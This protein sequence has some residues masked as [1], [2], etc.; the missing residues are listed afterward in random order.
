MFLLW[1]ALRRHGVYQPQPGWARH[2]TR[3]AT[4]C[5]VMVAILLVGLWFWN[6]WATGTAPTRILRLTI[7]MVA[8]GGGFLATLFACGFRL[9][10]LRNN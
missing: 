10:E 4:S 9:S 1:R 5:V 8:G 6:D 7:L 2:W 3:L